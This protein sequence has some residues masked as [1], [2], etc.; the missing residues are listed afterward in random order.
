VS[1]KEYRAKKAESFMK[2]SRST[3]AE[4][5]MDHRNTL[6]WIMNEE[7]GISTHKISDLCKSFGW[8]I[9]QPSIFEA[10]K[11]KNSDLVRQGLII[12]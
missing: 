9:K 8:S 12:E 11:K 5:Y 2:N 3:R 10:V 6:L 7:L 1:E 4:N